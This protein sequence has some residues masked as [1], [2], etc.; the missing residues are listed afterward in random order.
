[1]EK[2]TTVEQI[3]QARRLLGQAGIRVAFFLQ[4]GYPGETRADIALTLEMIRECKPDDIGISISYPLPGTKFYDRVCAQLGEKQNW[5]DSDDLAM[6]YHGPF[7]EAFYRALYL[8][9][10][11]EFRVRKA[12]TTIRLAGIGPG[13][14]HAR[15]LRAL[16]S[17]PRHWFA[18]RTQRRRLNC[19]RKDPV[20]GSAEVEK[21]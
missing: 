8:A 4:F 18:W 5:I 10:H 14:L 3:R 13:I 21:P 16:A 1:M 15:N 17:I 9:V 6:L 11:S 19:F 12:F 2:G 7:P 20:L